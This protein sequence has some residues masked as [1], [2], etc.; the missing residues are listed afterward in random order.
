M[1]ELTIP[2]QS[3]SP[4][5]PAGGSNM[6]SNPGLGTPIPGTTGGLPAK[7][8][9]S[10]F[11]NP[12][13]GQLQSAPQQGAQQAQQFG[14]GQDSMLVH[15][16]PNEVNSLRGLAQQFGGDLSVNPHTGLPEAGFLGKI[17]PT[18]LGGLGMLIPGMQPWMLGLMATAGGTAATGSLS[19]GLMMGLG[20]FG[21]A[22]LGGALGAQNVFG[23]A[24]K[25]AVPGVT[26]SVGNAAAQQTINAAAQGATPGMLHTAATGA[27]SAIAPVTQGATS[28]IATNLAG[29]GARAV[30]PMA[31]AAIQQAATQAG[32]QAATQGGGGLLG[33]FGSQFGNAAR[34]GLPGGIAAKAAPMAAGLGLLNAASPSV[35]TYKDKNKPSEYGYTGPYRTTEDRFIS[36]GAD[37]VRSPEG[38][39]TT[40]EGKMTSGERLYYKP[41]TSYKDS[42]GNAW[43]PGQ[44][45]TP[46]TNVGTSSKPKWVYDSELEEYRAQQADKKRRQQAGKGGLLR[47]QEE[48]NPLMQRYA[49]G[50]ELFHMES[51]GHVFPA[52]AVAAYGNFD[53][54][55]GQE[56]LAKLGGV[57]IRG[58][59]DGVSDSIPAKIDGDQDA[60]VATGEV[61]FPPKAVQ[62]LGGNQKLYA[63]MRNAE[64]AANRTK[65]G[66]KVK[67]LGA[68]R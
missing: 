2:P 17:L 63:M 33:N 6:P 24:A 13:A 43:T 16:T 4:Y 20:A 55:A 67:G 23:A 25:T 60:R 38:V 52:K 57:P 18:I 35:K 27:G 19:K 32:T 46:V 54:A 61:Y 49:E 37:P 41:S 66:E 40:P 47:Q 29:A 53:T 8:G 59:G 39:L 10:V 56:K 34:A 30:S 1:Q 62:R 36:E 48:T 22:S 9:L 7:P 28:G 44:K 31:Q 3:A 5:T 51:G 14:R 42:E 65:S 68:L 15:M 45:T 26:G 11:D 58:G 64:K 12:M 50:G 21:G